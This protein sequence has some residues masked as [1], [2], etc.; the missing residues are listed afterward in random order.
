MG[1]E[2]L[3]PAQVTGAQGALGPRDRVILGALCV[4]PGQALP[5]ETLAEALWGERPP[6]SWIKVVQ[7]SVMRLRR[8]LGDGAI[9]TTGAGYRVSLAEGE[10]D[11]VEFERLVARGR[12]FL[13][14]Q[15]PER[16]VSTFEQALG[17]WRGRPY[18]ELSEWEPARAEAARLL[19][20]RHAVEEDLVAASLAA[21]RAV[22][23]VAQAGPLVAREPFR[24]R[25]WALLATALYRTGRQRD[26]LD[27]LR[28]AGATLREELG[29]DPGTELVELEQQMLRQDP[30]LLNVPASLGGT[31]AT[32]PYRGLRAFDSQDADFYF[33]RS[34]TVDE[35]LRRI[36]EH[37]LLLVVGPSGSG[38]SSFV[39]AGLVPALVRTGRAATVVTPG[40]DPMASLSGA[41]AALREGGVL[42]TDQLEEAFAVH[43]PEAASV[44]DYLDRLAD[45][46]DGGTP[47]VATLR[48]DYLGWLAGSPRLARLAERGLL[49]LTPLTEDELREAIEAPARLVGMVLEPGLVDLLVRDVLGAPG[50]LPLLSHALVETWAQREGTVMTVTGYRATGGINSAVAKTAERL[51]ES[52]SPA[53]R[54]VLRSVLQR[55]VTPTPT[56]EPVA[57]RVPTRV[58][59]GTP[60]APRLLDLLVRARLV[61]TAQDTVTVAHESLVRAWPRLRTW[62]DEDVDGLRIL[63]HLQAAADSWQ[64][65]SRPDEELYHGARLAAAREWQARTRPVLGPV[66]EQFLAASSALE[67]AQ[68]LRQKQAH[69][70]QVR[71]NRQLA[72]ALTA[73][74]ALLA[75]SLVAGT[76]AGLRGRQ[77]RTQATRA[78]AAAVD[79]RAARLGTTAIAESNTAL[80]LL[81]ARQAVAMDDD[82]V[83]QGALLQSLINAGGLV[84]LA[85]PAATPPSPVTRDHAFTPDGRRLL[86]FNGD[87]E[88][89]LLDTENGRSITG[90]LAGSDDGSWTYHPSGLVDGG[91]TALVAAPAAVQGSDPSQEGGAV[92]VPFDTGTGERAGPS[93]PVPGARATAF[94]DLDRLRVSSVGH[95]LVSVLDRRIRIWHRRDG[96][97]QGPAIVP[98]PE[99]PR[100]PARP[101]HQYGPDPQCRRHPRSSPDDPAGS[102]LLRGTASCRGGRHCAPPPRRTG[103]HVPTRRLRPL[104][105]GA[106]TGWLPPVG[107]RVRGGPGPS[108][109]RTDWGRSVEHSRGVAGERPRL[110]TGRRPGRHRPD[111]RQS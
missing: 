1:I 57:T 65:L 73:V 2:L 48:A 66:E 15:Q 68:R 38:K 32:C 105:D 99:L 11:T 89:H 91:R 61:T 24:E 28:R 39:R 20:V 103:P 26:A 98:L 49:L 44:S 35:A 82:P 111:R 52:L 40:P 108:A 9:Q 43:P 100:Q 104:A 7:G 6:K 94:F 102:P 54:D 69:A 101:G 34:A 8:A 86:E 78:D 33:G 36:N 79:A 74:V 55:L 10:L 23:A 25:R 47:V 46:V 42:V 72:G 31:N 106:V 62:L 63:A 50:A 13:A 29:L 41:V 30:S 59:A 110:G 95:T 88:I 58:F 22:E 76:L 64:S 97:W 4:D 92:L 5:P 17:L 19:E 53:D 60:D 77:E 107:G 96:K 93:Q 21:G 16:A 14:L 18:L 3:G 67:E 83:T 75:V 90:P 45:L 37:A 70:T 81:L 12:E 109:G 51:Y 56:G 85:D 84:G 87:G 71:R 80:S 27:V